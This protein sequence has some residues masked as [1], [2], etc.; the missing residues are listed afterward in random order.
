MNY[1]SE[2]H[3]TFV[4]DGAPIAIVRF[5]EETRHRVIYVVEEAND[6]QLEELFKN[7]ENT[8]NK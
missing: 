3:A 4:K 6:D 5:N 7:Y 8:E 2:K 1:K